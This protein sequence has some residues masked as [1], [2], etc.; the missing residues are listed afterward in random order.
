M[1]S[2]DVWSA[3]LSIGIFLIG[4]F[5]TRMMSLLDKLQ[6]ADTQLSKEIADMRSTYVPKSEFMAYCDRLEHR[7][8]QYHSLQ[9]ESN[10]MLFMK[11]DVLSEKLGDKVSRA[12][13]AG[14]CQQ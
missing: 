6:S 3:V 1:D 11:L 4:L 5:M 2:H 7:L 10:K 12:E 8:E 13:C 14:K 9:V